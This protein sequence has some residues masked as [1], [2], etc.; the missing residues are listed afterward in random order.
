[1][2][3]FAISSR[4]A[5]ALFASKQPASSLSVNANPPGD[6][7]LPATTERPASLIPTGPA[8]PLL[9]QLALYEEGIAP[10]ETC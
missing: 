3:E 9:N 1:M 4:A 10:C 2:P 7:Q 5:L 6:Y 8:I